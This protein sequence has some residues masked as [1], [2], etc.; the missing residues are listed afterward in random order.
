MPSPLA[1]VRRI[2]AAATDGPASESHGTLE[3]VRRCADRGEWKNAALCC[4][5]LLKKDNLNATVHFYHGLVL[6]QMRNHVAA[7]RS[8]RQAIYLDRRFVLAHYYLGLSLQSRGDPGQAARSFDNTLD[9]LLPRC[10]AEVLADADG[11]TVAELMN[12]ARLHLEIL[13]ERA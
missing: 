8:L 5:R 11:I 9:L 2:D 1:P 10:D 7:E 13:R 6:E 3:D 4:E 12:L